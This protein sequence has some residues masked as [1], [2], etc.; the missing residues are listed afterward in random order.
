MKTLYIAGPMSGLPEFNYPAF[1]A[2]EKRLREA[3]YP[4]LNP[5]R[6]EARD[7]WTWI[8]YM[9]PAIRDVSNCDG[10]A[11]LPGWERSKGARVERFIAQNLDLPAMDVEI[12]IAESTQAVL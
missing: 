4:V 8:D 3:G 10:I 9:R 6:R 12:W 1:F 11:L 5:A 7:D 2:A